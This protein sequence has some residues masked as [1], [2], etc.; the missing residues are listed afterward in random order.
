MSVK[1]FKSTIYKFSW[2]EKNVILIFWDGI[3]Q[4]PCF[5]SFSSTTC[6]NPFA[7]IV[8]GFCPGRGSPDGC[9]GVIEGGCM[10]VRD[11]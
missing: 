6:F 7:G 3:I 4:I 2:G 1:S 10:A 8:V 9:R 11:L 5:H